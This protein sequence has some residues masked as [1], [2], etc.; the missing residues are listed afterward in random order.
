ML[1]LTADQIQMEM[2]LSPMASP[3]SKNQSVDNIKAM[4]AAMDVDLH[5]K[6]AVMAYKRAVEAFPPS[7]QVAVFLAVFRRCPAFVAWLWIYSAASLFPWSV[8]LLLSP[9]VVLDFLRLQEWV[10]S[11]Q[12]ASIVIAVGDATDDNFDEHAQTSFMGELDEMTIWLSGDHFAPDHP[13]VLLVVWNNV[14]NSVSALEMGLTAARCL[15]TTAVAAEFAKNMLSLAEFGAQVSQHGWLHGWTMLVQEW[16]QSTDEGRHKNPKYT[17][18]AV[19]AIRQ[20][21]IVA[22]NLRVLA[23]EEERNLTLGHL[24]QFLSVFLRYGLPGSQQKGR[25]N[26]GRASTVEITEII[27]SDPHPTD[28]S[29]VAENGNILSND[30]VALPTVEALSSAET[31]IRDS[32]NNSRDC[33]F[34]TEDFSSTLDLIA[35]CLDPGLIDKVS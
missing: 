32:G 26:A 7:H 23:E 28:S 3:S 35:S 34:P 9:F 33:R 1:N 10:A 15:Q 5:A 14:V 13:P 18:A 4:L 19:N 12:A 8:T 16:L 17:P 11:C 21:N 24:W 30:E 25:G 27:D 22:R 29:Q 20:G 2:P 31:F 6:P